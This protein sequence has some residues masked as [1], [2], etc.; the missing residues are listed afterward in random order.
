MVIMKRSFIDR[1]YKIKAF[2]SFFSSR[3]EH[4]ITRAGFIKKMVDLVLT[5]SDIALGSCYDL[6]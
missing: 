6:K 1:A 5:Q 3:V 2:Q 4:G